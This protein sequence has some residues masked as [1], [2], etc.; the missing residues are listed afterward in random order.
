MSRRFQGLALCA[1]AL[2]TLSTFVYLTGGA[3]TSSY[4]PAFLPSAPPPQS[5]PGTPVKDA[6]YE[7]E[8]WRSKFEREVRVAIT[9]VGGSHDEVV[10]ALLNTFGVQSDVR[11]ELYQ[12]NQ[13][14]GIKEIFNEF[15]VSNPL[16][17][18][19][20]P[21]MLMADKNAL[22]PHILVSTTCEMDS[23]QLKDKWEL[24]L[25]R[26]NTY[27]FCVV[28]HADRWDKTEQQKIMEPWVRAGKV[29]FVTLSEHT[30]DYLRKNAVPTW[31][32]TKDTAVT[33]RTLPPV[34][35]VRSPS[36]P[37]N[38]LSFALQGDYDPARR[39]YASIFAHLQSFLAASATANAAQGQSEAGSTIA[40]H[41]IGHS[42]NG[43]RPQVP[44]D[45][46]SN[47]VF[48]DSVDYPVFYAILSRAFAL[49]PAFASDTYYDRKASST[50]P[51]SLIAGV[52]LVAT[53]RLLETYSY[54]NEEDVWLQEE[55]EADFDVIG[56]ILAMPEE[57]LRA[58][59]EKVL[60]SR[61][62]LVAG[63]QK[64]VGEWMG[65]ALDKLRLQAAKGKGV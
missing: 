27:M 22:E 63:T 24:L 55:G 34:F 12:R 47:V 36:K 64:A 49:L 52:P 6:F 59:K 25:E 60:M 3:N 26:G 39:D 50:V 48:D 30:G 61:D 19:V 35:P 16:P 41:L 38:E 56:R 42:A 4:L 18:F 58:K 29:D 23:V 9:E 8:Q 5:E 65:E 20:Q 21:H 10:G 14:Y 2:L 45:L 17:A 1:V 7:R 11:L 43:Q 15:N 53:R 51:A 44:E 37:T 57:D 28:H 46:R 33:I 31:N 62:R 13:R 40:L 32:I 54:V